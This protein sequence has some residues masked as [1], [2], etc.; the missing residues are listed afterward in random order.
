MNILTQP[1]GSRREALTL[2]ALIAV[3]LVVCF[4]PFD[5]PRFQDALQSGFSL[6]QWYAREHVILCLL[7]AFL[8]AGA[9][10]VFVSQN[11][12]LRLL[13]P[14]ANKI[15]AYSAASVSGS[16]LAVCSCTVLP[17]FGGIYR[18]GAGLGHGSL[19]ERGR[20]VH[21]AAQ[22][23]GLPRDGLVVDGDRSSAAGAARDGR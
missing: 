8:I 15:T 23:G 6:L 19:A 22:P 13:G 10:P 16:I 3:F 18:R 1:G 21:A 9:I 20:R 12:V 2:V 14:D 5:A 7:P 17:L 4:V 11:A